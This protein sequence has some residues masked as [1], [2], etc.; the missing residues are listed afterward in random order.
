MRKA[1]SQGRLFLDVVALPV[2][3]DLEEIL[4]QPGITFGNYTDG[5]KLGAVKIVADGS[6]QGLTA[7]FTEPFLVDGPAG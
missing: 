2:F 3:T 5:L 6:P 7:Y 1:A 4:A